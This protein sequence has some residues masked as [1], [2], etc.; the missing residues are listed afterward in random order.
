ML[1]VQRRNENSTPLWREL[2][3][4][5]KTVKNCHSRSTFWSCI[6]EE[7][8]T[9]LWREAHF[10]VTMLKHCHYRSTDCMHIRKITRRCGAKHILKLQGRKKAR[11]CGEKHICKSKCEKSWHCRSSFWCS[12][13]EN[14]Y[15]AVA[16]S[17]FARNNA[18]NRGVL[19]HIW[20]F[21]CL[22]LTN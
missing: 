5:A 3:F 17:T 16:R 21:W 18:Q 22:K 14:S 8:G 6:L 11:G 9:P 7:N 2:N 12:D 10:E 13:L 20:R 4:E 15:A 19:Q 1:S